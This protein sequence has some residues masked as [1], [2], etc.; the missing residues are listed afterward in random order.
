MSVSTAARNIVT[1]AK[2]VYYRTVCIKYA[3][4]QCSDSYADGVGS[5]RPVLHGRYH[6][7]KRRRERVRPFSPFP[8]FNNHRFLFRPLAFV[9]SAIKARARPM[10]AVIVAR[11]YRSFVASRKRGSALRSPAGPDKSPTFVS[12]PGATRRAETHRRFRSPSLGAAYINY[13]TGVYL[14]TVAA[15]RIYVARTP[16]FLRRSHRARS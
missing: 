2:R 13:F 12:R 1:C 9:R 6:R 10:K 8:R 16:R 11:I 14:Q 4:R 7:D 15:G 3:L 5:T